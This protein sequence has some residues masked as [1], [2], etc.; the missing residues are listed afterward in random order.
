MNTLNCMTFAL[1]AG[2]VAT[3]AFAADRTVLSPE[4]VAAHNAAPANVRS[5]GARANAPGAAGPK[6]VGTS[7]YPG[8]P[9]AN[10]FRA[11]P[12]SCAADPLPDNWQASTPIYSKPIGLFAT[13]Q[14]RNERYVETVQVT[15]WRIACSSS[16]SA[17][18]YNPD[19]FSNAMTLVRLDRL[20]Q[21]E[22]DT[23]VFPTMPEILATQGTTAISPVRAAVEPNTVI[24]AFPYDAPLYNSTTFVLENF[25]YTGSSYYTFSD[26]FVL[27]VNPNIGTGVTPIEIPDYAPTQATYPDAFALQPFDGYSAAQWVGGPRNE[28]LIL[29]VTEQPQSDGSTVRQLVYDLLTKDTNGNSLWL[30]GNAAFAVGQ[31][32]VTINTYFLGNQLVQNSWG[33]AKFELVDCNHLDVTFSPNA[34]L[35]APIP[36][37]S[38]LA[39][40]DRLF[41][42][43]GMLC[44]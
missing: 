41:S 17:T 11:Y 25:P 13:N 40:Y 7:V 22:G 9:G 4:G 10:P 37:F 15:V 2:F 44:E 21:F 12:P 38:G 34:Q 30:V 20:P 1:A 28:G 29:Q 19:G 24:S 5:A 18:P 23:T 39:T 27:G 43:N 6:V 16:G 32:S 3:S 14:L 8:T 35:P 36:S 26:A 33:T 42:A 31:T